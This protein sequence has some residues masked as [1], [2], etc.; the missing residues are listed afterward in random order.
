MIAS[1]F[2][3]LTLVADSPTVNHEATSP[4]YAA[5]LCHIQPCCNSMAQLHILLFCALVHLDTKCKVIY[6]EDII[7]NTEEKITNT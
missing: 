7:K 5:V 6:T 1:V 3:K 2:E 4:A